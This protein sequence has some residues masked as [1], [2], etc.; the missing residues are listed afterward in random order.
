MGVLKSGMEEVSP[1]VDDGT[2]RRGGRGGQPGAEG[3]AVGQVTEQHNGQRGCGESADVEEACLEN[4]W[5]QRRSQNPEA[6]ES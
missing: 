6:P 5:L 2:Q 3:T 4:G 1:F